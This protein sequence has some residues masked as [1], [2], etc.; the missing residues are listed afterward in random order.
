MTKN[1]QKYFREICERLEEDMDTPACADFLQQLEDAP[2]CQ[3][4]FESVRRVV[5][6]YNECHA[7]VKLTIEMEEKLIRKIK[8]KNSSAE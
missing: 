7:T 3:K 5:D 4:F 8:Q 6:L 1:E 2:E